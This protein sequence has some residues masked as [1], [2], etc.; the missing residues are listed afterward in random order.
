VRQEQNETMGSLEILSFVQSFSETLALI[1]ARGLTA[2]WHACHHHYT[3]FF[4]VALTDPLMNPAAENDA[5]IR[6]AAMSGNA[7]AVN[8]FCRTPV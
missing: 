3:E 2:L 4:H 8:C 1:L 6:L 7:N 5:A